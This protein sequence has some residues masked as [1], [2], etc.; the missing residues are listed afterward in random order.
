MDAMLVSTVNAQRYAD[1]SNS[2][3][4]NDAVPSYGHHP[5]RIA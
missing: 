4:I 5:R 2:T 1:F 3:S